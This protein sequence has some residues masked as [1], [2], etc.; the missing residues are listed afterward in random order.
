MHR[1]DLAELQTMG[2]CSLLGDPSTVHTMTQSSQANE[3]AFGQGC[4][5]LFA[6]ASARLM[7]PPHWEMCHF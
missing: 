4:L 6:K 2:C 5:N 7:G 3:H 1:Q